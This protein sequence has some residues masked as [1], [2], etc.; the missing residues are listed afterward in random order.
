MVIYWFIYF[1]IIHGEDFYVFFILHYLK[2]EIIAEVYRKLLCSRT[3]YAWNILKTLKLK[4]GGQIL[5]RFTMFKILNS[6]QQDN[7]TTRQKEKNRKRTQIK[8]SKQAIYHQNLELEHG[9][10][11]SFTD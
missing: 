7:V 3:F 8:S 9:D 10:N 1:F 4:A 11:V 6:L 2:L 5:V